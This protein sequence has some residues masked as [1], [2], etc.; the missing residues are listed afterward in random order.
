MADLTKDHQWE[1]DGYVFG[2]GRPMLVVEDGFDPGSASWRTQDQSY[3]SGDGKAYGVDYLDAPT[4]AFDGGCDAQDTASALK[5]L[6][7]F[8]RAW[9]AEETRRTPGAVLPLRYRIA[10]RVRRVYGRPRRLSHAPT[11]RI[12]GGWLPI[13]ADFDCADALHY[14]DTEASTSIGITVSQNGGLTAPL[15]EPL[16]TV[17]AGAETESGIIVGGDAPT[18]AVVTFTGPVSNPYV[19]VGDWHCGLRGTL[20]EGEEVT[21]DSRP[22]ARSVIRNDGASMGGSLDR[23]TYLDQMK[24]PP[25]QH[26]IVYGGGSEVA[27]S[28]ATVRWR[29]AYH[30]L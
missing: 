18:W 19:E 23:K 25:G 14:D 12:L 11:N 30:A 9:R 21:I 22:W 28:T 29:S 17:T 24:L 7:D 20:A 1:L 6:A 8:T 15:M 27:N 16:S 5:T 3:A 4:W 2:L 10:G 26:A 13:T